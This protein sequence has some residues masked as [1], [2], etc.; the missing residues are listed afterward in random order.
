MPPPLILQGIP[1]ASEGFELGH[2]EG[3]VTRNDSI[4]VAE[5]SSPQLD[6][7]QRTGRFEPMAIP[8]GLSLARTLLW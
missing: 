1:K 6:C 5:D 3:R 7:L 4:A 2:S 8:L